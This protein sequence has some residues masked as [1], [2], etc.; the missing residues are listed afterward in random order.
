MSA[1]LGRLAHL[2]V[3]HAGAPLPDDVREAA[4][5]TLYNVLATTVGAAREPAT[6]VV[7]AA[8]AEPGAGEALSPGR[9]ERLRPLD[10]ALLTGVAAHLD[11]YDDTHLSTVIHPGAVGLGALVGLAGL[12]EDIAGAGADEVLTAFAWGVEAQLRLGVAISPE[13]YDAGWHITG[14]CGAVGAAVTAGLLLNLGAEELRVALEWAVEGGLGNREGFGSMTKPF[15]PGK[16]AVNGLRAAWDVATGSGTPGPGDSLTGPDGL[17]G[18]LARGAFDANA[19]LDDVGRRWELLDNTFK[20]YPCGIVTHP[21]IEAAEAL[22]AGLAER[23]GPDAVRA[24]RLVCH[25][26]VPELTGNIQ[27]VDGLQA[28][29]STAHGVAAGLLR[30]RVDLAAYAD[31]FVV[32][33]PARRLR[34]LVAF[35]P[36]EECARDAARIEVSLADGGVLTHEVTHARGSAARPLTAEELRAKARGLVD[37]VRAGGA[38]ALDAATRREGPGYLRGLLA[39]A[40]PD[41][42]EAAEAAEEVEAADAGSAAVEFADHDAEEV[43]LAHLLADVGAL[44]ADH[45]NVVAVRGLLDEGARL[46]RGVVADDERERVGAVAAELVAAGYRPAVAAAVAPCT[47]ERLSAADAA[48]AVAVALAVASRLAARLDVSVDH[49]PGFAAALATVAARRPT[50]GTALMAI[51]LAGTQ[52]TG[53]AG[54]ADAP[55]VEARRARLAAADAVTSTALVDGGFTGPARPLTGRRGVLSLLARRAE[56]PLTGADL[57]DEPALGALL[58]RRAPA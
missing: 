34:A 56:P 21:A 7:V 52:A 54:P 11:D 27:P 48:R 33:A 42:A 19:L 23:G 31:A 28:R 9:P 24:I 50:P 57:L 13:H 49:L 30:P 17:V 18:R 5:R 25:P 22:H 51:G 6:G 26:L 55:A 15:H 12:R 53:V 16:A 3:S 46:R 14:T 2:V 47:A 41:P 43:A 35:A 1:P 45:P 37:R 29:F 38:D 36:T 39:A 8:T 10:A 40:A 4:R 20:P 58:G 44:P 32:S